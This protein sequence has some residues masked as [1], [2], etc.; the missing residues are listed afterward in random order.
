MTVVWSGG[1]AAR[2]RRPGRHP[3]VPEQPSSGHDRPQTV[4]IFGQSRASQGVFVPRASGLCCRRACAALPRK[5]ISLS[6]LCLLRFV[7]PF[8]HRP[9]PVSVVLLPPLQATTAD[10]HSPKPA[11]IASLLPCSLMFIAKFPLLQNLP[12]RDAPE[13]PQSDDLYQD[14]FGIRTLFYVDLD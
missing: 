12:S 6:F 9:T 4:L 7:L 5:L 13:R 8:F 2:E 11:V 3:V 10:M 14:G 1:D